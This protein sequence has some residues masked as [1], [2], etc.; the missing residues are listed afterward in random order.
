MKNVPTIVS[1]SEMAAIVVTRQSRR[2]SDEDEHRQEAADH[3][4]VAHVR[5]RV[6][7]E[8]GEVVDDRQRHRRRQR[9]AVL[10]ERGP[11]P[12]RHLRGCC[13]GSGGPR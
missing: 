7:D 12:V 11:D 10:L 9:R 8:L 6:A 2:N 13:R 3:D 1:G 4:G 5:H